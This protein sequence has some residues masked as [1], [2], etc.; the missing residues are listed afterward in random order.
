RQDGVGILGPDERFRLVVVMRQVLADRA[1]EGRHTRRRAAADAHARDVEK[2]PFDEIEPG[3]AGRHEMKV[4]A[5][6]T[7]EPSSD[8]WTFVRAEVVQ[9][10]MQVLALRGHVVEVTQELHKLLTAV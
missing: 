4:H 8:R 6:M 5:R 10:E 7:P 1:L 9:D 2:P 3:A